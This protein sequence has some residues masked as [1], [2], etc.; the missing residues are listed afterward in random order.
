[1]QIETAVVIIKAGLKQRMKDGDISD[2]D[3]TYDKNTIN[4]I[5][6]AKANA[7]AIRCQVILASAL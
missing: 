4:Y 7:N 1:M 3:V 6:K 5:V 2:F